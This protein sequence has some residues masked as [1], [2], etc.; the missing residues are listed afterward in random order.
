M[1]ELAVEKAPAVEGPARQAAS[2]H[3]IYITDQGER[4]AAIIPA[5]L[6]AALERLSADELDEMAAAAEAAGYGGS[7]AL[8]EDLADRAAVLDSRADP[9]AGVPHDQVRTE[10][11]L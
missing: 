11:G 5:D 9:G 8:L 2:G 1:S 4:L 6:A 10:A 7:A 3:V